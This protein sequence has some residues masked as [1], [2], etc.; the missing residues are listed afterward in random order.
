MHTHSN[1][2]LRNVAPNVMALLKKKASQE[3]VSVNSLILQ[4]LEQNLGVTH[5]TKKAVFHDLDYLAGT[6]SDRDKKVFDSNIKAFEEI[7]KELW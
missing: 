6:W 5:P 7:D 4:I 2:N 3:K 1:F